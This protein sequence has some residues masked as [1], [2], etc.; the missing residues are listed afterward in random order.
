[1]RT[2]RAS[3]AQ[4]LGDV[5]EWDE[6]KVFDNEVDGADDS[7]DYLRFSLSEPRLVVLRLRRMEF[8][9]DLFVELPSGWV[10]A[11]SQ[12]NGTAKEWISIG[13]AADD[14]LA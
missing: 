14:Y 12:K 11:S 6:P 2:R 13:L 10:L 3:G 8:D 9:A 1:M 4:D 7:V 5:T